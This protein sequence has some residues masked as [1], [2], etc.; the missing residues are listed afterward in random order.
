MKRSLYSVIALLLTVA[1]LT[2]A[3]FSASADTNRIKGDPTGDGTVNM[4]DVTTLQKYIADLI[5]L[6]SDSIWA[7]D[8]NSDK[9]VNMQDVTNMQKFI[10]ELITEFKPVELITTDSDGEIIIIIIDEDDTDSQKDSDSTKPSSDSDNTVNDSDTDY[11]ELSVDS[12]GWTNL[13]IKP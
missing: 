1:M 3:F 11:P 7:G 8:V 5:T 2:T 13:I 4:Q 12:E 9:T 6:D 10:A